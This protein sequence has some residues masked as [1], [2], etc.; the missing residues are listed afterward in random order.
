VRA[1]ASFRAS[2]FVMT[3]CPR[4]S[5]LQKYSTRRLTICQ[6]KDLFN[7]MVECVFYR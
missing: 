5:Q 7:Q 1:T 6:A 2:I 4:N 3:I